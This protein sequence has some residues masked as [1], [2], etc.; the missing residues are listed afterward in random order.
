VIVTV[1]LGCFM[2]AVND[3]HDFGVVPYT[4]MLHRTN[5]QTVLNHESQ[6]RY[7]TRTRKSL[8]STTTSNL[9]V[10]NTGNIILVSQAPRSS[11]LGHLFA[12][13]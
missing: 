5:S 13:L 3:C 7:S 4:E 8:R 2:G 11:P 1:G 6:H 10:R 12:K 9:L